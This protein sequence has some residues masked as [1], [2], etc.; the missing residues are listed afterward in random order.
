MCGYVCLS[1]ILQLFESFNIES[2]FWCA[3]TSSDTSGQVHISRLLGKGQG[4]NSQEKKRLQVICL[5][6]KGKLIKIIT[7][8]IGTLNVLKA[9]GL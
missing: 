3:G 5:S 1:V 8:I 4:H 6:L 9:E 7:V 2:S